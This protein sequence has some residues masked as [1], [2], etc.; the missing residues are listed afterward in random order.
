LTKVL[1]SELSAFSVSCYDSNTGVLPGISEVYIVMKVCLQFSSENIIL[2][3]ISATMPLNIV[4]LS[5]TF[6][7]DVKLFQLP[8]VG[9]HILIL[10][11]QILY[12]TAP[13]LLGR[14]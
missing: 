11:T 1:D 3:V 10:S 8:M 2:T 14:F 13:P 7:S 12:H 9:I 5:M 6:K 4:P